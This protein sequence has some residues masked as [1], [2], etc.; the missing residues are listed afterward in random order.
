MFCGM[1]SKN[2]SRLQILLP[3]ERRAELDRLAGECGLSASDLARLAI[4]EMLGRR[5]VVL[6]RPPAHEA[7]A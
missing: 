5:E 1:K 3:A 4:T 6:I 7:A 2:D